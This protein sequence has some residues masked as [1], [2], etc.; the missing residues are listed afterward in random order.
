MQL[1]KGV[2]HKK[3]TEDGK[4]NLT[5]DKRQKLEAKTVELSSASVPH[6]LE[7]QDMPGLS[8]SRFLSL[9]NPRPG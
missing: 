9:S 4:N 7:A 3:R 6:G 8:Y 1:N 5:Y 2:N